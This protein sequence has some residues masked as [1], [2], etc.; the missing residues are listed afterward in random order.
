MNHLRS[1]NH[2]GGNVTVG[3]NPTPSADRQE[4]SDPAGDAGAPL[5]EPSGLHAVQERSKLGKREA[6][7]AGTAISVVAGLRSLMSRPPGSPRCVLCRRTHN[8]L[9]SE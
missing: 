9:V 3:S 6:S 8:R 4:L 2:R 7:L 5:C 1:G